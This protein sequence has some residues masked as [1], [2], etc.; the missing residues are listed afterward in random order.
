MKTIP[1][2]IS[3]AALS[4]DALIDRLQEEAPGNPQRRWPAMVLAFQPLDVPQRFEQNLPRDPR[5]PIM[6]ELI[7]RGVNAV[8]LLLAHLTDARPTHLVEYR[9][10][11]MI[12][13]GGTWFDDQYEPRQDGAEFNPPV[14]HEVDFKTTRE[15]KAGE[16]YTIKVGDLCFFALGQIVDRRLVVFGSVMKNGSLWVRSRSLNSPV[17]ILSLAD[18]ARKDWTGLTREEHEHHLEIDAW[19]NDALGVQPGRCYGAVQRLLFYYPEDGRRVVEALIRRPLVDYD[20]VV[21]IAV[22]LERE[23]QEQQIATVA[24][25]RRNHPVEEYDALHRLVFRDEY[26]LRN[27]PRSVDRRSN[28]AAALEKCFPNHMI[29]RQD[30]ISETT[31]R[32]QAELISTLEPFDWPELR[33]GLFALFER[34]GHKA[35]PMDVGSRLARNELLL[36]CARPLKNSSYF[37]RCAKVLGTEI[38]NLSANLH[39]AKADPSY[40]R[41][42]SAANKYR[43]YQYALNTWLNAAHLLVAAR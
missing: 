40:E 22:R 10:P 23:S 13:D 36:A 32:D 29:S 18:A 6:T 24:T 17:E 39:E 37:D 38:T 33:D 43:T 2:D 31:S 41:P 14:N 30:R 5:S 9:I 19:E 11:N 25:F 28:L 35:A 16:S 4:T 34:A 7:R 27:D 1:S 21:R 20:E 12:N 8:P 42:G 15:L 3:V 26:F